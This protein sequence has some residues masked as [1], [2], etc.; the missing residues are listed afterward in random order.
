MGPVPK[1]KE[2]GEM[3]GILGRKRNWGIEKL[4]FGGK[5]EVLVKSEKKGG[6]TGF[7]R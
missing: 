2:G 1:G 5:N 4:F 6:K 7:K 3:R